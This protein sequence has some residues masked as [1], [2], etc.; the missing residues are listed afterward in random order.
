V[1]KGFPF[2]GQAQWW[3]YHLANEVDAG[4]TKA[5]EMLFGTMPWSPEKATTSY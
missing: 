1:P 2:G 3:S 5:P 4:V